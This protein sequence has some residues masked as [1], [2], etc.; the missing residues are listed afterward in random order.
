M[1]VATGLY[2]VVSDFVGLS[3]EQLFEG[4]SELTELNAED[5]LAKVFDLSKQLVSI[6]SVLHKVSYTLENGE[7]VY[8]VHRD[9]KPANMSV[10]DGKVRQHLKHKKIKKLKRYKIKKQIE[11]IEIELLCKLN[12]MK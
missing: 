2:C 8:F 1:R 6:L 9:I 10:N 7:V 3:V 4:E 11:N 12:C 5:R